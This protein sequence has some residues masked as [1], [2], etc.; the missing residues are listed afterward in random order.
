M[1]MGE[2]RV[3][4]EMFSHLEWRLLTCMASTGIQLY[5]FTL[6]G[7]TKLSMFSLSTILD[8]A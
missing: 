6:E 4:I 1:G 5:M 3:L 8:G 7:Q 2:V